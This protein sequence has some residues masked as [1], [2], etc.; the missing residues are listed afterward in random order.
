[1]IFA[2]LENASRFS[3]IFPDA[4]NPG[5]AFQK[6]LILLVHVTIMDAPAASSVGGMVAKKQA[7]EKSE[8]T[9]GHLHVR[10]VHLERSHFGER[11]SI[12]LCRDPL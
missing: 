2:G 10:L 7:T 8:F 5:D 4:A 11:N 12:S 6:F 1:M 3:V 9:T